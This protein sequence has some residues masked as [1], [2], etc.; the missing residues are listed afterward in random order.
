MAAQMDDRW[1]M[2]RC[3]NSLGN[4]HYQLGHYEEAAPCYHAALELGKTLNNRRGISMAL[5]N[6]ALIAERQ[7]DYQTARQYHQE[8]LRLKREIGDR[9]GISISLTNLGVIAFA[10]GDFGESAV[11]MREGLEICR[12][13]GDTYGVA[14]CLSNLADVETELGRYE[15]ARPLYREALEVS[16]G[17]ETLPL[18]M[19]VFVSAVPLFIR[20]QQYET[21]LALIGFAQAHP[22]TDGYDHER[23]AKFLAEIRAITGDKGEM[24]LADGRMLTLAQAQALL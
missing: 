22:A 5:N 19:T 9:A 8:S 6:L 24:A 11:Y 1:L 4:V 3:L 10:T 7:E 18:V 20:Q 12:E 16:L 21:A 13:I 23:L 2:A 14:L 17:I 15:A